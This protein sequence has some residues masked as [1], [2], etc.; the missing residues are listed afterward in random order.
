MTKLH[1]IWLVL[2]FVISFGANRL[3]APSFDYSAFDDGPTL[4]SGEL[5]TLGGARTTIKLVD[6][7]VITAD[8]ATTFGGPLAVRHLLLRGALGE[9]QTETDFEMFADLVPDGGR[10]VDASVRSVDA[11][12]NTPLMVLPRA[13][14]NGPPSRVRLPGSDG[15]A[16]VK[17][18]TL[19]FNEALQIEPGMWRVRG[20]LD[21]ELE[22]ANGDASALFARLA[23]RLVWR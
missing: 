7:R 14:A 4:A 20:D 13:R 5:T 23:G 22:Q 2:S 8:V 15:P 12:K 6:I 1:A 21:L 19:T 11:F 17:S 10:P 18:G 16:F 3:L 9:G